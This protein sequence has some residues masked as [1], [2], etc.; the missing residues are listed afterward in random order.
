MKSTSQ[1]KISMQKLYEA[2][3]KNPPVHRS[4]KRRKGSVLDNSFWAGYDNLFYGIITD[5]PCHATWKAGK[6]HRRRRRKL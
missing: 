5:S 4:G 2:Y 6:Y 1:Q 3:V